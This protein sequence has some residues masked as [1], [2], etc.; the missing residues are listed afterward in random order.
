MAEEA[1]DSQ[2]LPTSQTMLVAELIDDDVALGFECAA[3]WLQIERWGQESA[4]F[5]AAAS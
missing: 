5:Q 1:F 4:G 3:P 2:A